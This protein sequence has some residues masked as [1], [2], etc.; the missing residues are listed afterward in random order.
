MCVC[1]DMSVDGVW[2]YVWISSRPEA[3]D[4]RR[5]SARP[6]VKDVDL[7]GGGAGAQQFPVTRDGKVAPAAAAAA[8]DRGSST[9]SR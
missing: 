3:A 4:D 6:R 2:T 9:A 1:A 5:P 7:A 8:A